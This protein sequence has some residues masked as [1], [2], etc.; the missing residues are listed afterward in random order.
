MVGKVLATSLT[1]SIGGSGGVFAP[2]LFIGAMA[3]MAFGI[4]A[5]DLFGPAIGPPAMYAVVAMGGVFGAAAQAPL[6]AIASVVEMTGN[7]TLT[8]PVMLADR[9]RRGAVQASQLRQHLHHQAAAP[10]HRHR[11]A[12]D[13]R[14]AATGHRGRSD[15]A[16]FA[17]RRAGRSAADTRNPARLTA[18]TPSS[19][20]GR[21]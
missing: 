9:H 2:S 12:E 3:G 18:G 16:F 11:A 14:G 20:R 4:G 7:F 19:G 13:E 1:L 5:H 8:V 15:A 6:T 21:I 10:R 17:A